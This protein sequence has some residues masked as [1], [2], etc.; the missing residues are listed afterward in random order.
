MRIIIPWRVKAFVSEH[1]PLFYHILS[2]IGFDANSKG[3]WDKRLADTWNESSRVWPDKNELVKTLTEENQDILD[4]ACGNGSLL[5]H[6]QMHGY[7][8][9]YGLEI[10]SYAVD[11]LSQAGINMKQGKLPNLP[12]PD[13]SFDVVIASQI[14]EHIIRRR[15]FIKEIVRVLRPTGRALIF[16][17]ND[18]LCPIDEKEHVI[19]YSK[20][21]L[22]KFLARYFHQVN[23]EIMKDRNHQM[24]ILAA[25]VHAR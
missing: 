9:L 2:N 4:I 10:S 19:K 14:L 3:H 1:F 13:A 16:V 11:K 22:E 23:V 8:S 5:R 12:Y 24:T 25:D 15:T 21:S 18:C 7:N 20:Y 17:P 6:L